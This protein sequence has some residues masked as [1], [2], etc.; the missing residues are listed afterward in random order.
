MH[1]GIR[2]IQPL[3]KRLSP[4]CHTNNRVKLCTITAGIKETWKK[5]TVVT[6][7]NTI[8]TIKSHK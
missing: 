7:C 3:V 4:L 6:K 2:P 5:Q 1:L 8:K